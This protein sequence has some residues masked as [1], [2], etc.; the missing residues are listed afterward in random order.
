MKLGRF[1]ID[2]H[3]H[4]QRHAAG[5]EFKKL[6]ITVPEK[7][8]YPDLSSIMPH[9]KAFD[10]SARLLYDME[11]YGVDMC[12]LL[13]A[14][15]MSN[16]IN[17]ALVEKYPGK[18]VAFCGAKKTAE[19]ALAGEIEWTMEAACEELDQ[20]LSTGKFVGIGEGMPTRPAGKGSGKTISH[21]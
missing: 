2:T 10:N 21:S 4:A 18:F 8:K 9:L 12:I 6:G 3:V 14:F 7:M 15:G 5:P 17:L 16:D 19:K 20:L 1:V 11:R 13:P